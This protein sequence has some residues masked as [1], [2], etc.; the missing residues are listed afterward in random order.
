MPPA[1]TQPITIW[2]ATELQDS[3]DHE[4]VAPR[5]AA[6]RRIRIRRNNTGRR[7]NADN[8]IARLKYRPNFA[9]PHAS[10]S[11]S[12]KAGMSLTS[13]VNARCFPA[14]KSQGET[15]AAS[16]SEPATQATAAPTSD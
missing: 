14:W 6:D 10:P 3:R 2:T 16:T 7:N 4:S 13:A 8:S 12:R 5:P 11:H 15:T 9:R 1:T